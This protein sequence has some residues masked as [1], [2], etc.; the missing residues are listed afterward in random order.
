MTVESPDIFAKLGEDVQG[1]AVVA[2]DNHIGAG[3]RDQGQGV[4]DD[5]RALGKDDADPAW[6]STC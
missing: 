2:V 5:P 6:D 3:D 4:D 1:V